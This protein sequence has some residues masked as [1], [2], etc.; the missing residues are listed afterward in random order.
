MPN[1][2]S[3]YLTITTDTPE[4]MKAIREVITNPETKEFTLMGLN[5]M[6]DELDLPR[7]PVDIIPDDVDKLEHIKTKRAYIFAP[8]HTSKRTQEQLDKEITDCIKCTRWQS[9][10]DAVLA[11]YPDTPDWYSWMH[12]HI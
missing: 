8:E 1:R 2:N 6:P 12:K 10:Q 11:K 9:E 5:P 4:E 7:S 3:N